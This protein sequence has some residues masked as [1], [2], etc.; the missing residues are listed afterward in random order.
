MTRRRGAA[1]SAVALAFMLTACGSD[2]E[3]TLGDGGGT[4]VEAQV[5]VEGSIFTP[6][7]VTVGVG[8]TVTWRFQDSFAHTVTAGDGS[9]DSGSKQGGETF[10]HTFATAGSFPYT[11][12]IHGMKGTV[13]VG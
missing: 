10:A 6:G 5:D 2:D 7:S 11:C 13:V 4:A 8:G 1:V 9:F 3:P 12:T